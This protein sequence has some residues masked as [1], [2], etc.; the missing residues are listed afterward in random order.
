MGQTCIP[1]CRKE[2]PT[3]EELVKAAGQGKKKSLHI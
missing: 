2:K 3:Q 1:L